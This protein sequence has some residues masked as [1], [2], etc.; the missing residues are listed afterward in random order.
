M[1]TPSHVALLPGP[2]RGPGTYRKQDKAL[3]RFWAQRRGDMGTEAQEPYSPALSD[4]NTRRLRPQAGRDCS[5]ICFLM[6]RGQTWLSPKGH[7][8]RKR[9]IP[10]LSEPVHFAVRHVCCFTSL[11]NPEQCLMQSLPSLTLQMGLINQLT[12]V[13]VRFSGEGFCQVLT[14][15]GSAQGL[16]APK[17]QSWF[18]AQSPGSPTSR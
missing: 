10:A 13:A 6:R 1:P 3:A 2:T 11:G 12:G 15:Q 9:L 7:H 5:L 8:M 16:S 17:P 18:P 14:A 4:D